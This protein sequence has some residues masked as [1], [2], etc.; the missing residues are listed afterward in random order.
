[1]IACDV[2]K[3]ITKKDLL[4]MKILVINVKLAILL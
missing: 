3:D 2:H 1:M 4:K